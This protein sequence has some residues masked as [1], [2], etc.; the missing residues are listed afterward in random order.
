MLLVVASITFVVRAVDPLSYDYIYPPVVS[1]SLSD[2][3][4]A[5]LYTIMTLYATFYTRVVVVAPTIATHPEDV[6]PEHA[7][8]DFAI[9]GFQ[10][11]AIFLTWIVFV[12][13][14]LVYLLLNPDQHNFDAWY[15]LMQDSMAP[16]LLLGIST[17]ALVFGLRIYRRLRHIQQANARAAIIAS[18]RYNAAA[19]QSG[20]DPP[21]R[22]HKSNTADPIVLEGNPSAVRHLGDTASNTGAGSSVR[23]FRVLM[24]MEAYAVAVIALHY[25]GVVLVYWSFG[26]T[27][28]S[29]EDDTPM[30]PCLTPKPTEDL[31][32][33]SLAVRLVDPQGADQPVLTGASKTDSTRT[34]WI[35]RVL[36]DTA[37][38]AMTN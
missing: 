4:S 36:L 32:D 3:C 22:R 25:A 20:I 5:C 37:S 13:V 35:E 2:V 6:P 29:T 28:P 23:I 15:V 30:R 19:T 26:K 17:T 33:D 31:H 16:V 38:S 27:K 8:V 10:W 9:Q 24:L 7:V 21:Q 34:H 1:G 12:A 18:V 11:L 14:R